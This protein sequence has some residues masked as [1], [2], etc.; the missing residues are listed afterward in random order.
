[1]SKTLSLKPVLVTYLCV[2]VVAVV[3]MG[4]YGSY[5]MR[6]LYRDQ[7]AE[8]L[9]VRARLCL[10]SVV[11]LLQ[12]GKTEAIDAL[13]KRLGE[14]VQTR[15]TVIRP[16]GEVIGDTEEN[17]RDMENHKKR[18]EVREAIQNPDG[19]G[20][21]T[22]FSATL[23]QHM[24]YVAVAAFDN[25]APFVLVRT[26]LPN[27]TINKKLDLIDRHIIVAGF[28]AIVLITAVSPWLSLRIDRRKEG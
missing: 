16:T 15:I 7:T 28:V 22:H 1:M 4:L 6:T 26:S 25:G 23:E 3:L 12:Q 17:P 21:S 18:P 5:M 20:R 9:E 27:A 13:C 2:T 8:D 19:V 10:P 14:P 11:E 24:T